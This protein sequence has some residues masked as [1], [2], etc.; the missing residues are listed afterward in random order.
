MGSSS[1]LLQL[2]E[3]ALP[4]LHFLLIHIHHPPSFSHHSSSQ[5]HPAPPHTHIN[6]NNNNNTSHHHHHHHPPQSVSPIPLL[7][8]LTP[9]LWLVQRASIRS[10][11]SQLLNFSTSPSNAF[12][13]SS[14]ASQ[15]SANQLIVG[16]TNKFNDRGMSNHPT[17]SL[18]HSSLRWAMVQHSSSNAIL[19]SLNHITNT[20]PPPLLAV[21]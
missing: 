12:H 21:G 15:P 17:P 7:S 16:K 19:T 2:Q 4:Q 18:S 14:I 11:A 20:I 1:R 10:S 9:P 3:L 8:M 13:P 6:N 5:D